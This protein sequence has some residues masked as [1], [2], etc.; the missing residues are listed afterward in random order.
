MKRKLNIRLIFIT[1]LAIITTTVSLT[2]VYYRL[3]YN[4]IRES[5]ILETD[6]L[7]NTHYFENENI[8]VDTID[9]TTDITDLRVTWISDTGTVLY[10]NDNNYSSLENHSDREEVREA[11]ENGVGE[12]IRD[13]NTMGMNTFYYAVLLDNGTVLRIARNVRSMESMFF[14]VTP[15]ILIIILIIAIICI[16]ISQLLTRQLMEPIDKL[17]ENIDDPNVQTEYQELIP[18]VTKI[19]NQHAEILEAAKSRQDFTAN[20]SHELKTP[21]TSILGYSEIIETD[22]DSSSQQKHFASQIHKNANRLLS[23]INDTIRLSELDYSGGSIQMDNI[24][25]NELASNCVN[26]IKINAEAQ[27][28]T[29]NYQG[30]KAMVKGN[31]RLLN[32]VIENLVDN[33]IR[34]NKKDGTVNVSVKND[35]DKVILKVEDNGIGIPEKDQTHVFERFYRVDKSRS[36]A[37]GGTGLG[38][39]I[40]KHISELHDADINLSSSPSGTTITI[41]FKALEKPSA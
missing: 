14:T 26:G 15:I 25:L 23:L 12:S 4:S 36:K 19:R 9:L 10:D 29:L 37:T 34:Y 5:L 13:S 16:S 17:A 41:T 35:I 20:V 28:I 3:F 22:K 7:R 18:F 11:F 21:L 27:D 24:D 40:V 38:L 6:L 1:L 39:A 33:A 2:A 31:A 8:D 30:E 32:E